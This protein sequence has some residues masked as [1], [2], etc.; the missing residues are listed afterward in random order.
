MRGNRMWGALIALG[1]LWAANGAHAAGIKWVKSL[2]VAM[3]QAK[4]SHK[5]I[6]A[7]F[8]TDWCVWCKRLDA[9]T[10]P[11]AKV[12]ALSDQ[13]IAVKVNAEKEGIAAAKKYSVHGY[14][15]ILFLNETGEVEGKI[16]GYEP[17]PAFVESLTNVIQV[18][19]DFPKLLAHYK[20]DPT[21]AETL[22]RLARIYASQ[23]KE[24]KANALLAQAE[25]N[26]SEGAKALLPKTYAALGD[27]YQDQQKFDQAIALFQKE[28]ATGKDPSDLTYAHMSIA[29]CYLGQN[30]LAEALPELEAITTL[31][32]AP[33]DMKKQAEGLIP[34]VKQALEKAKAK[35]PDKTDKKA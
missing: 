15:T 13:I 12:V 9:D 6:M 14:P 11:D 30:K 27:M 1:L 16:G 35:T 23:G 10:Y 34:R 25:K 28:V 19:K 26:D 29:Y 3:V 4:Q 31:P 24:E 20:A 17:A 21:D 22:N 5:L 8:Y 33:A 18:H 2:D 7:D 32:D